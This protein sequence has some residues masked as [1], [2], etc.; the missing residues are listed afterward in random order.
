MDH[1]SD[2]LQ[3]Q[4]WQRVTGQPA[5]EQHH[6]DLENAIHLCRENAAVLRMLASVH[7]KQRQLL[8]RLAEEEENDGHSL[9]GILH[10]AGTQLPDYTIPVPEREPFARA[11]A[12]CIRRAREVH[13]ACACRTA[14]GE[15]GSVYQCLTHRTAER[16]RA[17]L[18]M[19]G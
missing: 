8:I 6:T 11:I 15:F 14:D 7:A 19:L 5:P 3:Q 18:A 10:L 2:E 17:E 12:R 1:L 13:M 16:M 9:R 4:I